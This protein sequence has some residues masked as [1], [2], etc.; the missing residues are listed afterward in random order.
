MA[1]LGFLTHTLADHAH[2]AE[3]TLAAMPELTTYGVHK[4][5]YVVT[6]AEAP[7]EQ[8]EALVDRVKAV[9]GVLV[10]YVTSFTREDEELDAPTAPSSAF[11]SPSKRI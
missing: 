6:V 11:L 9:E 10:V 3:K 8:L 2:A 7:A 5:C 1:I 4:G